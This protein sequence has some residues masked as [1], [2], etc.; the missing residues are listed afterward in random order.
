[1]R[2]KTINGR[3]VEHEGIVF[4]WDGKI[5]DGRVKVYRIHGDINQM[6][7]IQD[8]IALDV[9]A[10]HLGELLKGGSNERASSA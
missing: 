10:L 1:M 8:G 4:T 5:R 7:A 6:E 2:E 9:A 3:R